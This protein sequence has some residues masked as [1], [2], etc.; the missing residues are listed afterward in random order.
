MRVYQ[1]SHFHVFCHSE[2]SFNM[3]AY[4]K[5]SEVGLG[6][7]PADG[8]VVLVGGVVKGAVTLK[9]KGRKWRVHKCDP[10]DCNPSDF[11]AHDQITG[12]VLDLRSGLIYSKNRRRSRIRLKKKHLLTLLTR[13]SESKEE[14]FS[15][16]AKECIGE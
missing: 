14:F 16:K 4:I 12:D 11:H 9:Q 8:D 13:L 2:V 10:D 3:S 15:V 7:M 5:V 6:H 1:E